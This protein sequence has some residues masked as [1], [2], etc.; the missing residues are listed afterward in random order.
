MARDVGGVRSVESRAEPGIDRD[1]AVDAL[2]RRHCADLVGLAFFLLGDR[3]AAEEV[4]QDAFLGLHR[5]WAG[6][7]EHTAAVPYLRAAVIYGCRSRQ[8]RLVR[9]RALAVR[10]RPGMRSVSSCEETA[11]VHED[12]SRL[13]AAMRTLPERQREVLYCRFYLEMSATQTADLLQIGKASVS[14]HTRRALAGLARRIEVA[15]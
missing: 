8:R 11:V 9:A 6:M 3:G 2:F 13:A 14:T 15:S 1:E 10:L 12:S 4:V 5:G 7:R